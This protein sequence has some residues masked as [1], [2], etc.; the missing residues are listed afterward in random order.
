MTLFSMTVPVPCPL[1][2]QSAPEW[3]AFALCNLRI[4]VQVEIKTSKTQQDAG[5][6]QKAADYVHAYLLGAYHSLQVALCCVLSEVH[7][8]A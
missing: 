2:D 7:P 6:L 8:H 5:L 4:T 1:H 3:K